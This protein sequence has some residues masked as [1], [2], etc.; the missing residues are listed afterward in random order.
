VVAALGVAPAP[1]A[2]VNGPV[3]P[4]VISTFAVPLHKPLQVTLV[5][6]AFNTIVA[7]CVIVTVA[8]PVHPFGLVNVTV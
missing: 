8:V 3:P 7:G 1:Q 2:Y 5:R 4:E 6:E